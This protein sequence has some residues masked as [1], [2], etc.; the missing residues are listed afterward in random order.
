MRSNAL[1]ENIRLQKTLDAALQNS[2][3][4]GPALESLQGGS[5]MGSPPG[6]FQEDDTTGEIIVY[7]RAGDLVGSR[8][9]G[10]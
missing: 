9:P 5:L 8:P 10:I 2:V 7:L 1:I 3:G 4:L 6:N